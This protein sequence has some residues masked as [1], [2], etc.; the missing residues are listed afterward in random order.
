M[1]EHETVTK[2]EVDSKVATHDTN[3]TDSHGRVAGILPVGQIPG[4]AAAKIISGILAV[5][6]IPD[7]AA[8]KITSGVLAL[9]RI[10][11]GIQGKLTGACPYQYSHPG[12]PQCSGCPH[13]SGRYSHPGSP[14][15]SGCPHPSGRY[16]HPTIGT[17]PQAPKAHESTHVAGGSDDI[18]SA[19]AIAAMANLTQNKAWK[20][21]ASNRPAEV[22][23][24][25]GAPSGLI[26]IWHGTIANIPS[27]WVICDGN[28]GTPNMLGRF[29][30]GVATAATDPG[31]TGGEA[32]HTLTIAEMPAHTHSGIL[33]GG[34][35]YWVGEYSGISY[36][37]TNSTGGGG[38]HQNKPPYYD[39]A[40]LMKT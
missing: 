3:V 12:T 35:D 1:A 39:V 20:G 29:V 30:E 4:L 5:A 7:L 40:F 9:A 25:V 8:S 6:R 22:D 26:G 18:D 13:P 34:T 19:L 23:W 11:T 21:N 38:S 17:C 14:V 16:T 28:N 33:K 31:A 36:G 24:P 37:S 15:C 2:A 27:G 32:T 10:P